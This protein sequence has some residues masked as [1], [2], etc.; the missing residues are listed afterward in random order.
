MSCRRRKVDAMR[1]KKC[2]LCQKMGEHVTANCPTLICKYCKQRGHSKK[3]CPVF[4][5]IWSMLEDTEEPQIRHEAVWDNI[6]VETDQITSGSLHPLETLPFDDLSFSFEGHEFERSS[7]PI[8]YQSPSSISNERGSIEHNLIETEGSPGTSSYNT[9]IKEGIK[10]S[11]LQEPQELADHTLRHNGMELSTACPDVTSDRADL[12]LSGNINVTSE[13]ETATVSAPVRTDGLCLIPEDNPPFLCKTTVEDNETTVEDG[14]TTV[15]DN[16]TTVVDNETIE[17]NNETIV[18]EDNE[19]IVDDNVDV[20]VTGRY[21]DTEQNYP[22][23]AV[24]PNQLFCRSRLHR[25]LYKVWVTNPYA[26]RIKALTS[27]KV[28]HSIRV[29]ADFL[30]MPNSVGKLVE[31]IPIGLPNGIRLAS[32]IA[33]LLN[34]NELFVTFWADKNSNGLTY[35][36]IVRRIRI[37]LSLG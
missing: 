36:E 6:N 25:Q 24:S 3:N 15:V 18:V 23:K 27:W 26:R 13:T 17:E 4:E 19:T 30:E 14:E 34:G 37:S 16:E 28:K 11:F 20:Y 29:K 9:L 2:H 22:S 35:V 5:N 7:P 33:P 10:A 32:K 21:T 31:I 12:Y 8:V 1:L